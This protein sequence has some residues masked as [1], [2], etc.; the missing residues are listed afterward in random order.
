MPAMSLDA[1][2]GECPDR[3]KGVFTATTKRKI[4]HGA[5]TRRV[6]QSMHYYAEEMDDGIVELQLLGENWLPTGPRKRISC[7]ELL[8]GYLPEPSLFQKE[9]LPRLRELQKAVARGDKYRRRGETFTAEYEYSKA[10]GL[11]ESNVRANFGIGLCYMERGD[12]GKAREVF[13]RVVGIDAAFTAEHKHLFNEFGISLRK[14][15][16]HKEAAE[17]YRRALE[18]TQSDENL[19]YNL[20]RALYESG[21]ADKALDSLK[22]CLA[23]APDHEEARTFLAFLEKKRG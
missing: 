22:Q 8:S 17:Y 13:Q 19:H 15:G 23:M 11:D 10:L 7:D 6:E 12:E 4:G 2:G 5:T 16:M 21:A 20:A 3:I 14:Q 9:V 18:M 1:G